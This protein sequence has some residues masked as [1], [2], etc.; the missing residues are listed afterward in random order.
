MKCPSCSYED[1]SY[2]MSV[3]YESGTSVINQSGTTYGAGFANDGDFNPDGFGAARSSSQG[4]S[5]TM[6]AR[7][8]S[9]P[10]KPTEYTPYIFLG[11]PVISVGMIL[12]FM[13]EG[14]G[15]SNFSM[16]LYIVGG[17]ILVILPFF[18]YKVDTNAKKLYKAKRLKWRNS[19]ICLRCGQAWSYD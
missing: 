19:W 16:L 15:I 18:L 17:I 6:L 4:I 3:L 8:C 14:Y 13:D 5:Q 1:S 12:Q 11:F 9:P 7:K 10:E 2:R